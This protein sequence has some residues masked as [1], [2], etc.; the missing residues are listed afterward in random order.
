MAVS[1][2]ELSPEGRTHWKRTAVLLVPGVAC[3]GAVLIALAQG[4][5]A[6]SFAVSGKNFKVSADEI[7]GQGISSFPSSLGDADGTSHP[8][9]L[10]GIKSGTARGVCLSMKQRLPLV[11][12]VSLLVRSGG[13]R[14]VRGENLVVNA[15]A[16]TSSG[17]RVT[18][19]QAG[20]DAATLTGAPGVSGPRGLFGVQASTALARDVK[21]TAWASNGGSL[22]LDKVEIELSHTGKECY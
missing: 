8:V 11:G 6:A 15:D 22:T 14:P 18:G 13:D 1:A 21:S 5:M 12:E 4:A 2:R 10:A 7:T 3:V 17:G 9:L 16:L 20:R 19:V